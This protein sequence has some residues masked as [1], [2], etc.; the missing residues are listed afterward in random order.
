MAIAKTFRHQRFIVI[1]GL[2]LLISFLVWLVFTVEIK[3]I[4]Q[5][6]V[7]E[8][9]NNGRLTSVEITE[10]KKSDFWPFNFEPEAGQTV[11]FLLLGAP[12]LGNDGANLTDTI[13]L[14]RLDEAKN[15]IYLFSLPRDLLVKIPNS[16]NYAKL[17]ALYAF[18]KNNAGQEFN[19]LTQKTQDIT[20]LNIDHYIFVDLQTVQQLVDIFGGVNIMVAKDIV[21]ES[22]PGANHS[23]ETFTLKAGWRYLDGQTALKYMR[24]RH[25]AAG[26]FDRVDRQQ[27]VL[28]A[29]KQKVLAL[30]FWDIGKFVEI[31]NALSANIKSDLSLWQIKNYWDK[32]K[33]IPGANVIKSELNSQNL[34]TSG[35]MNLG[36]QMASVLQPKAGIENYEEIRKYIEETISN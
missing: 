20:G 1:F 11:N 32:I 19:A 5:P 23:F 8:I 16:A 4:W 6:R 30:N 25:S 36:G 21:D 2:I 35:Q 31:Y 34:F 18:N 27:E 3:S 13:L 7:I 15:K 10:G 26:D 12:G 28:R 22:F 9:K 29:L 24:T 14:A 17:N 33:G